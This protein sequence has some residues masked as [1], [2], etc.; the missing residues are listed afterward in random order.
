MLRHVFHKYLKAK[1]SYLINTTTISLVD[2]YGR[3]CSDHGGSNSFEI[4]TNMNGV[5][6]V[7]KRFFDVTKDRNGQPS[8]RSVNLEHMPPVVRCRPVVSLIPSL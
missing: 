3:V 5:F 7:L 2:L 1:S 8:E 4:S 6:L